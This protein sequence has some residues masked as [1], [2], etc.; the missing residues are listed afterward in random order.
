MNDRDIDEELSE[1][2]T[3][4]ELPPPPCRFTTGVAGS[5]K[6]HNAVAAVAA[7]PSHGVLSS[8]TGISAVNLGAITI[9]SLL[10]YSDLAVMRDH[11]LTG[12]LQ[13]AIHPLAK[14]FRWLIIDE[15]SMFSADAMDILHRAVEEA[16]RYADV[17]TPMGIHIIGDF[18]QLPPVKAPWVFTAGCWDR[19]RESTETLTK[20]WRQDGGRFLDALN[21]VRRGEG[22]A[23]VEVLTSAGAVFHSA[24]DTE[25][26]GTTI[27]PRNDQVSRYNALAL[28]R[29]P[30]QKFKVASRRWGQQRSEW[31]QSSRTKEWG[32]PPEVELKVGAYVMLLA[33]APD[34][35]Y[36]NGDCGWIISGG[37]T[38]YKTMCIGDDDPLVIK[39]V[40]TSKEIE[41]SPLVRGVESSDRPAGWSSTVK[42]PA[43][44]DD[45]GWRPQPHYRGRVKRWVTGQIEYF[46]LRLAYG[47]TV[48]K[49]QSLTLDRVQLD[50]RNRFFEQPAMLY[51]AMSRCRTLAGLRIIGQPEVFAK[52]CK[53]DERVREWL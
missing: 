29:V 11:F 47:T 45:G 44:E 35:E 17:V 5:G 22:S 39:L 7:D 52:H 36:V 3:V 41:L 26:E 16:N 1:E 30:G 42:V 28:D 49:S 20:V 32:V 48:H 34:F 9:N 23:A 24:L 51:T 2:Q 15:V 37:P 33:N 18:C 19:F 43:S 8:T 6:T 40:R 25:F 53:F 21:L 31:G 4:R 50:F 14:Q 38:S 10:K 13:R 46:P 12:A 27:L